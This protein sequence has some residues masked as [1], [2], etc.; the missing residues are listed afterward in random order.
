MCLFGVLE[1]KDIFNHLFDDHVIFQHG[2]TPLILAAKEGHSAVIKALLAKYADCELTDSV[3][4]V[5]KAMILS[6]AVCFCDLP[7]SFCPKG[8]IICRSWLCNVSFIFRRLNSAYNYTSAS[9]N[10]DWIPHLGS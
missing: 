6:L 3:S 9:S 7:L 4:T 5:V 2:D 1:I 10:G 8:K